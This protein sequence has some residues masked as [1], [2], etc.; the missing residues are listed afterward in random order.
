MSSN[1]LDTFNPFDAA[2]TTCPYPYL[3]TLRAEAPVLWSEAAQSFVVSRHD[4]VMRIIRDPGLFSSQ[5][6][7]AG[8]PVPPEWRDR[9]DAVIAEGYP[10]VATLLTADP[11]AHTRY[12]RLVS[13]AFSPAAVAALEPQIRAITRR[14]INAWAGRRSIEFVEAFSVPLPVEVIARALNV[15]DSH[16]AKFK[17]WSDAT[18]AAIG[19]D[20][21]IEQLEDSERSVNEFQRYFAEQLELRRVEPQNDLLT[22]LLNATIDDDDPEVTDRRPLDMA[23]MLRILQQILVAGN[24]TTT[25]LL[26]DLMV[27]LGNDQAQWQH[28]RDDPSYIPTVVEEALRLAT[29]SS[30]IWRIATRD[31]E[32]EGVPI[33]AGSRLIITWMSANRDEAVFGADAAEFRPDRRRLKEH[34]AFGFGIHYC[35]GAS[36]SRLETRVALEELTRS[37]DHFHLAGD[38]DYRY[39]PS[40]FLRGL[41]RLNLELGESPGQ[42]PGESPG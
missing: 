21:S 8:R 33:P 18:T 7:R 16:L 26:T 11:P 1:T 20:I 42:S 15:P 23:E 32:L 2:V 29:P 24:E 31:T 40:F 41:T 27:L 28:M 6:G 37:F 19:T 17:E 5:F 12:R 22:N 38:N 4:V 30:A 36:L 39:H 35:L 34:L 13:K 14:L 10:R 3:A 9:I 25:S